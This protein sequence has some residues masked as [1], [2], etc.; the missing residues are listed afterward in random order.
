VEDNLFSGDTLF[1]GACGRVDMP[2]GEPEKMWWSLNKRLRSLD[3]GIVLYPG[4]DY[5]ERVTSTVGEQK[6]ANPYMNYNSVQQFM[7]DMG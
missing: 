3:D 2:G 1:V 7:R 6:R 4:H 5:G